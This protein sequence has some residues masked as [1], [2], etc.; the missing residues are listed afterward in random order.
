[1]VSVVD[2]LR[3][4]SEAAGTAST[5]A[6]NAPLFRALVERF[7]DGGRWVVLDCGPAQNGTIRLFGQFRCR[8]DIADI[9]DGLAALNLEED[10]RS[11]RQL[12]EALLPA[13]REERADVVLCWDLPNYLNRPALAALMESIAARGHP[14]TFVHALIVYSTRKMPVRP[15]RYIP[16]EELRLLNVGASLEQRDAPRY[17]PEDLQLAMPS[18]TVERAML[19]RNGM[20]EFL[21][22]M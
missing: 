7:H 3:R 16:D 11:V 10:A 8:L 4:T 15:G 5:S 18:F 22:R 9:G 2:T 21:F 6:L 14:G 1:M 20:Q 17:S 19:L 13:R 12:A